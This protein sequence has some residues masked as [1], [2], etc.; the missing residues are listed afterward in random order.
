MDVPLR[1][2]IKNK[3]DDSD[4]CSVDGCERKV[5]SKGLCGAHYNRSLKGLSLDKPLR[6]SYQRVYGEGDICQVEGCENRA[7]IA[8]YCKPHYNR[9]WA[10]RRLDAEWQVVEYPIGTKR[11]SEDGYVDIKTEAGWKREHRHVMEQHL[12]RDLEP[13]ETVHHKNGERDDNTLDNLE[14][15]S[16]AHPSGQRVKDKLA[17]C[18]EFIRKY[19]DARL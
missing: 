16:S 15:W 17:W 4:R 12:G 19:G 11:K 2:P 3:Y 18:R 6:P 10:G 7:A 13:E 5:R 1:S 14:L 8:R 9:A